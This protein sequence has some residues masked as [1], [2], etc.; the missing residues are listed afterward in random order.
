MK[1][2]MAR[3]EARAFVE[4]ML[5][6]TRQEDGEPY[7]LSKAP[8]V[9]AHL[10]AVRCLAYPDD[11]RESRYHW[12]E[13]DYPDQASIA[14]RDAFLNYLE[15]V[16]KALRPPGHGTCR[17]CADLDPATYVCA[18]FNDIYRIKLYIGTIPTG[19]GCAFWRDG[20]KVP[21]EPETTVSANA[22]GTD[23]VEGA[24]Q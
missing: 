23:D 12:P 20:A 1:R 4:A 3:E 22:S 2:E 24:G 19:W 21:A 18:A 5:G 9:E 7:G 15:D 14:R 13:D 6:W 11:F 8:H 16:V 17:T 10:R